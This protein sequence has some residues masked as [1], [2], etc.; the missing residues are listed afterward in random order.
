MLLQ[1]INYFNHYRINVWIKCNSLK[2]YT[3]QVKDVKCNK[4]QLCSTLGDT[5]SVLEKPIAVTDV[6]FLRYRAITFLTTLLLPIE[7]K[8]V[9]IGEICLFHVSIFLQLTIRESVASLITFVCFDYKLKE[10]LTNTIYLNIGQNE[11]NLYVV[12]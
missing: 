12:N 3:T 9:F 10:I 8:V 5:I 4:N 11:R 1:K 2:T 7:V 6:P